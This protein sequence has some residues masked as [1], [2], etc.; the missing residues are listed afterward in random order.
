MGTLKSKMGTIMSTKEKQNRQEKANFVKA[1]SLVKQEGTPVELP[2]NCGGFF[3]RL[4]LCSMK[5][6]P[7]RVYSGMTLSE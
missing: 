4:Y 3:G 2:G 1:Y 5:D 7:N 6:S